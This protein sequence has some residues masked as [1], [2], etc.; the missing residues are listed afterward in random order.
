MIVTNDSLIACDV[1]DT[2]VMWGSK[3]QGRAITIKNPYDGEL[4]TLSINAPN[5]KILRQHIARGTAVIVWSA[6]GYQWAE[7]VCKALKIT[8]VMIMTK[9]R[10][11]IDDKPCKDWMGERIY[12]EPD[13]TYGKSL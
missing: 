12:L 4:V 3:K 8:N 2:L 7:A 13:S 11:Y 5:L 1:D 10:A 9:P 6:G